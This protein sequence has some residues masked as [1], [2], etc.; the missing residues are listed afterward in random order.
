VSE[1]R[2]A[3]SNMQHTKSIHFLFIIR[4]VG[5][6]YLQKSQICL[7]LTF[8]SITVYLHLTHEVVGLLIS[9]T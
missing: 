3:E 2:N 5:V 4:H 9:K 6:I 8:Y 7:F 1:I